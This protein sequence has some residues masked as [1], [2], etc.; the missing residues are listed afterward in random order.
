VRITDSARTWRVSAAIWGWSNDLLP[1]AISSVLATLS[2]AGK[3]NGVRS[4]H[5]QFKRINGFRHHPQSIA[6]RLSCLFSSILR[7][8]VED[9]YSR[10]RE[11]YPR[12]SCWHYCRFFFSLIAYVCCCSST[13]N[14]TA[15]RPAWRL[16]PRMNGPLPMI[17]QLLWAIY[18]LC[19]QQNLGYYVFIQESPRAGVCSR[20][21]IR[22]RAHWTVPTPKP[23]IA[24]G[25]GD[26]PVVGF[27]GQS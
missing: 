9:P 24:S 12:I 6:Y 10:P 21:W 2:P 13:K 11:D 8:M 27:I 26:K 5:F 23:E 19:S 20:R 3:I 16:H 17:Y 15:V 22:S 18:L 25:W 1:L 4:E 7:A 14:R